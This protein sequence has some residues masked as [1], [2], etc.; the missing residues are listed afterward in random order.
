MKKL[1]LLVACFCLVGAA[2]AQVDKAKYYIEGDY[3]ITQDNRGQFVYQLTNI[4]SKGITFT[5]K[6]VIYG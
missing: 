1:M 4:T 6:E 3:S 5:P 2:F